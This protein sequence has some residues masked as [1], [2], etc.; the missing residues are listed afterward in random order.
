MN[1]AKLLKKKK[2]SSVILSAIAVLIVLE[3]VAV[4]MLLAQIVGYSKAPERNYI[5]LTE[6]SAQSI[7]K[8]TNKAM[9]ASPAAG[10]IIMSRLVP[11]FSALASTGPVVYDDDQVWTTS[12]EINIFKIKYDNNGD[13]KYTVNSATADKVIAP[14]TE[15]TYT[16]T[17]KN[18]AATN[19]QYTVTVEA[20]FGNAEYSIPVEAKLYDYSNKYIYGT[21]GSWAA[22]KD[23]SVEETGNLSA[24]NIADYT[25]RWQ[26][27]YES[28]AESGP[29]ANDAY[30]TLLG[31]LAANGEEVSLNITIKTVAEVD[32]EGGGENPETGD[33][34]NIVALAAVAGVS[35]VGIVVL[36]V[37]K[38]KLEEE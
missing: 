30:D 35:I 27:P 15:N 3:L 2:G 6:G 18:S 38:R 10:S 19:M 36:F 20:S 13:L 21:S 29:E 32:D 22:V 28:T 25:L 4:T 23:L 7:V 34:S 14:G 9:A 16:F 11:G 26:W 17:L 8:V 5:S 1:D 12:T 31:N 24:G 33:D 37:R